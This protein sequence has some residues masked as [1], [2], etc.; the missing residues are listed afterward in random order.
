M[1]LTPIKFNQKE[2]FLGYSSDFM[3]SLNVVIKSAV[4]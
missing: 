1:R 3:K 2:L 4:A